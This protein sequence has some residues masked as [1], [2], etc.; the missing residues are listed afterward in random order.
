M[1]LAQENGKLQLKNIASMMP[2]RAAFNI[3]SMM[4]PRAAFTPET[5]GLFA[6][7]VIVDVLKSLYLHL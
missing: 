6:L 2:P 4:P 7:L 3:A 5:Y 1:W